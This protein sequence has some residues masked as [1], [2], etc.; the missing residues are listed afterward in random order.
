MKLQAGSF[1]SLQGRNVPVGNSVW[2]HEARSLGFHLAT[3]GSLDSQTD[4]QREALCWPGWLAVTVMRRLGATKPWGERNMST[5]L[6]NS[7]V[8]CG[9]VKEGPN[10]GRVVSGTYSSEM[11]VRAAFGERKWI[12]SSCAWVSFGGTRRCWR[13]SCLALIS[14]TCTSPWLLT[15]R[16]RG[17]QYHH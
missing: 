13:S 3:L 9:K 6:L 17:H 1:L 11:K 10:A 14:S 16:R 5:M 15:M 7:P 4:R 8:F 12:G 2:L